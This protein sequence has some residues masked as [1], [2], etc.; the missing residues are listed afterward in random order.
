MTPRGIDDLFVR[1]WD[2]SLTDAQAEEFARMLRDDPA[3]R[4]HFQI[5]C[6]QATAAADAAS[7]AVSAT[8]ATRQPGLS[9]RQLFGLAGVGCGLTAAFGVGALWPTAVRRPVGAVLV[10]TIGRVLVRSEL[11]SLGTL[12]SPGDTLAVEGLGSSAVLECH[13]GSEVVL[14]GDTVATLD[15]GSG[16]RLVVHRGGVSADMAAGG[17]DAL[18]LA[19]GEA[20]AASG[21]ERSRLTLG[22]FGRQTEVG[23]L[24]GLVRLARPGGRMLLEV[25]G[26][27]I[28]TVT[29]NAA[30]KE[31]RL[32]LPNVY[33]WDLASPLPAGWEAGR[34]EYAPDGPVLTA[35]H[36][37]GNK[38]ARPAVMARSQNGW[39]SGLVSLDHDSVLTVKYRVAAPVDAV[40]VFIVARPETL[41]DSTAMVFDIIRTKGNHPPGQWQ[42]VTA[43]IGD[44]KVSPKTG[45]LPFAPPWVAYT[46]G[47]NSF[48]KDI[49][50]QVA[51]Y[52]IS[53]PGPPA[54][55]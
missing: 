41:V 21:S 54:T 49:G 5:L 18:T 8:S 11:A 12:V 28:G 44:L 1:Y 14:S 13:D 23:V 31:L 46:F 16:P 33:A 55:R 26:G 7:P 19:T 25:G 34:V 2:N 42:T 35:T 3:A 32:P 30:R 20:T 51:E 47:V 24:E 37:D 40:Q 15:A 22:R 50:L 43:R 53:R 36:W 48:D 45:S 52:R 10:R 27:E 29:P 17:P 9:R 38:Y 6:L 4:Q 39:T